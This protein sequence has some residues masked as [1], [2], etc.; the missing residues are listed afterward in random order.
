MSPKLVNEEC[1]VFTVLE[2]DWWFHMLSACLPFC[3]NRPLGPVGGDMAAGPV[4]MLVCPFTYGFPPRLALEPLT[5][6][7]GPVGGVAPILLVGCDEDAFVAEAVAED[8]PADAA[9]E[10]NSARGARGGALPV[11][12]AASNRNKVGGDGEGDGRGRW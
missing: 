4:G 10:F 12:T 1:M 8:D 11:I 9:S 6:L 5:R 2:L 3:E 7:R